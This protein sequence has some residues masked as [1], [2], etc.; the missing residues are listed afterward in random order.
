MHEK[1]VM[2]KVL[3]SIKRNFVLTDEMLGY[4]VVVLVVT[5]EVV[6]SYVYIF[7]SYEDHRNDLPNQSDAFK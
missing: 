6:S 7:L 1:Y 4:V 2:K 5:V 3:A